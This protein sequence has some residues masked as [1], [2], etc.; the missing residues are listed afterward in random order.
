NA[1]PEDQG[2]KPVMV[3]GPIPPAETLDGHGNS[4]PA[5]EPVEED[6]PV[7]VAGL[8][9]PPEVVAP[10]AED[11]GMPAGELTAEAAETAA[12]GTPPPTAE[13]AAVSASSEPTAP[14]S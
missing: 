7:P 14:A 6:P 11:S 13:P 4:E 2:L 12:E 8:E 5:A 1:P 3:S 10:P 9:Q